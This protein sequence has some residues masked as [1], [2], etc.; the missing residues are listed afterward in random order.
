MS[1][2]AKMA[3]MT[4]DAEGMLRDELLQV[5]NSDQD[6]RTLDPPLSALCLSGGGIRSA[7]FNLGVV[8]ALAR[9]G[10]LRQFDYL[11]TVSGGGYIGGWL[12]VLIK[13]QNGQTH[14]E[15]LRQAEAILAQ[16]RPEPVQRLRDFGNFL[17]PK[18][19][20]G[21][22]DT[23][24]AVVLYLRNLLLNWV[25]LI[26]V[27]LAAV[28][29]PVFHRTAIWQIAMHP[30]V[31]WLLVGL[32][33]FGLIFGVFQAC[34]ALPSHQA[35][36]MFGNRNRSRPAI[37]GVVVVAW[38]WALMA[39][40]LLQHLVTV[41]W[42][43]GT[44]GPP[45]EP[46]QLTA[47]ETI[48]LWA[49]LALLQATAM[50]VGYGAAW[51]LALIREPEASTN[52]RINA[53]RWVI[54]TFGASGLLAVAVWMFLPVLA[55]QHGDTA[56]WL[57]QLGPITLTLMYVV[58]SS[59]YLGM[60]RETPL[61][62]LDREWLARLDGIILA[63][64]VGWSIFAFACIS[65]G[66]LVVWFGGPSLQNPGGGATT[67]GT[68]I[69]SGGLAAW[70]AKQAKSWAPEITN[71]PTIRSYYQA[72][73][74]TLLSM[75]F[76]LGLLALIGMQTQGILGWSVS[77]AMKASSI[78]APAFWTSIELTQPSVLCRDEELRPGLTTGL[79]CP[80]RV[81]RLPAGWLYVVA[82]IILAAI[83]CLLI[84][85]VFNRIN[86]NRFSMHDLYRNR[87]VRAFLGTPRK[88]RHPEWFTDLDAGDDVRLAD[89]KSTD[90]GPQKL[91]P[92]INLA[93]NRSSG[94]PTGQGE[95]MA[96]SYTA[97]PLHCGSAELGRPDRWR[98][99]PRPH[100]AYIATRH[101]AGSDDPRP[102]DSV[103]AHPGGISL[104]TMIAA[105]GA[106]TSPHWGYHTSPLTAFVM[107]LFNVR[108]GLWL[109]NPT[110][111][112]NQEADLAQSRPPDAIRA[113]LGD[114][115]GRT[116][117]D[118]RAIHLSDGGHFDNLGLYEMLRRR[119]RMI[120]VVDVSA[121]PDCT[122]FDLG[123]AIRRAEIDLPVRVT[124]QRDMPIPPRAR[125]QSTPPDTNAVTALGVAVGEI[126][127]LDGTPPVRPTNRVGEGCESTDK[128]CLIYIKPTYLPDIPAATRAY[129]TEHP[130]F[131]H[132][133]TGDQF[134]SES[135]FESYQVLG[136]FQARKITEGC[137]DLNALFKAAMAYC[138]PTQSPA[139]RQDHDVEAPYSRQPAPQP[140]GPGG[141]FIPDGALS[142][143]AAG[144]RPAASASL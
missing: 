141:S 82:Q 31:A 67:A 133:S 19:G 20:V 63:G 21:S 95:R 46:N 60:R 81:L 15:K 1:A 16:P 111:A 144:V 14:A 126:D 62:N 69:L 84:A 99:P 101:F 87:L 72:A 33:W 103:M 5:R 28:L 115:I 27:L 68:A 57:T 136:W 32:T 109:P 10:L 12:Q 120:V 127:Y 55:Y 93:L 73:L 37:I 86:I 8:R 88:R 7:S 130:T 45:N 98:A 97:T 92:V 112:S 122:L 143:E 56:T 100:S 41:Q 4:T 36:T 44:A 25:M 94:G 108:L 79:Y 74:P 61:S 110:A 117:L 77:Q 91:F 51:V 142:T 40:A 123:Q 30:R 17:T 89:L 107:T 113:L 135:Q 43:P 114:L 70:L 105:S 132:E 47:A 104:G 121:D 140:P 134:F 119:C 71:N 23:W 54:A 29:A 18:V 24:G 3:S 2:L 138:T 65:L 59:F 78:D 48:G 53:W 125:I 22:K 83:L 26:P 64:A 124:M 13:E 96:A 137:A 106:A 39:P 50:L 76:L 85:K 66:P 38:A 35:T 52:Y 49:P 58:Q 128:G 34:R 131:P 80:E 118:S 11:S 9:D 42:A 6:R 139:A 75:I 102:P 116:T 90:G 129:G